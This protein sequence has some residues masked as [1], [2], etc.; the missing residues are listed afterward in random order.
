[1]VVLERLVDTSGIGGGNIVGCG[2]RKKEY[3]MKN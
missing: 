1:M 3:R 2:R